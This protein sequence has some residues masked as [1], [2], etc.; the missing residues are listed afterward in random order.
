[1]PYSLKGRNVLIT[2]GSRGLGELICLKFAAEG[3]NVAVNYNASEDR[4]KEV[5]GKVE[6]F[7]GKA[8]LIKGDMGIEADCISVV[9]TTISAL[10]GL[11][12]IIS[13]AGYTRFS[14]FSD[15]SAPTAQDWDLCH[16]INVKAQFFLVREAAP[17]F[18]KNPE[19][20]VFVITS[21]IAGVVAG[22]SSMPYSV[23]K[24]AQLHLMKCLA[25]TEGPKVRVNA[26]LPGWLATE[27]GTKYDPK[28]VE[29]LRE[30]SLLKKDTDLDDCAQAFV[31]IAKNSSMTGQKI[32]V[33][34]GLG[35]N[36]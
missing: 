8:V 34:S 3:C 5:A 9:Q 21:S 15:L 25:R 11:D 28:D 29:D 36:V 12:I 6:G 31:D 2:G 4:A 1:M 33:D 23:T 17:T 13:N 14:K 18:R 7:G 24:A 22:G 10:S 26:V 20:G 30:K 16:A 35:Q 32:Q 19:G 27:W